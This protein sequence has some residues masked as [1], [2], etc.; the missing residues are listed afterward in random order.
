MT[1][2]FLSGLIRTGIFSLQLIPTLYAVPVMVLAIACIFASS[3]LSRFDPDPRYAAWLRFG[4]LVLSGLAM[5]LALARPPGSALYSGNTLAAALMGLAVYATLLWKARQ[6]AYL[7]FAFGALFV[8]YFGVFYFAKDLMQSV[9][10]AVAEAAGYDRKLPQA[11]KSINGLVF[12]PLLA[13]LSLYFRR[14][15]GDVKL[16][17]HCHYLGVPFAIGACLFSTLEPK[18]AAI[19]LSGYSLLFAL[20]AGAFSAPRVIYLATASLAGAVISD[21]PSCTEPLS[22]IRHSVAQSCHSSSC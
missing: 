6:P 10:R 1:F 18:A 14:T 19:C 4:G 5:A 11:F 22:P 20:G 8:A 9:E 17:R 21:Q 7:Y 12:S 13:V 16:A 3:R 15:W 2:A